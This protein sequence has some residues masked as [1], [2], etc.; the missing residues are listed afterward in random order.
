MLE[1]AVSKYGEPS[2]KPL[3]LVEL[4]TSRSD[5][6]IKEAETYSDGNSLLEDFK[7]PPS[8]QESITSSIQLANTIVNKAQTINQATHQTIQQ[9]VSENSVYPRKRL[10]SELENVPVSSNDCEDDGVDDLFP[11]ATDQDDKDD[12]SIAEANVDFDSLPTMVNPKLNQA[13]RS[14]LQTNAKYAVNDTVYQS[15]FAQYKKKCLSDLSQLDAMYLE[16]NFYKLIALENILFLKPGFYSTDMLRLFGEANLNK[17]YKHLLQPHYSFDTTKHTD[18]LNLID[19]IFE[20]ACFDYHEV[21]A[22]LEQLSQSIKDWLK[23]FLKDINDT[24]RLRYPESNPNKRKLVKKEVLRPDC[25]VTNISQSQ[26]RENITYGE[27]KSPY[28]TNRTRAL[29]LDM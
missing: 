28:Y 18:L 27:V 11:S 25:L 4:V 14:K 1:Q 8:D 20:K 2:T 19:D 29:I 13:V 24:F 22:N 21:E 3:Q 6:H 10:R 5:A 15:L 26:Y 23:Y 9:N 16:P 7:R 17:L 12:D